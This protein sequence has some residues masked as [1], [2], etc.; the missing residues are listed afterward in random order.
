MAGYWWISCVSATWRNEKGH[1]LHYCTRKDEL[2]SIK[3]FENEDPKKA[4]IIESSYALVAAIRV[5]KEQT[6][7]LKDSKFGG[8]P[9]WPKGKEYPVTSGGKRLGMLAQINCKDVPKELGWPKRGIVQF[10]LNDDEDHD[11]FHPLNKNRSRVIYHEDTKLD[12]IELSVE[13]E[14]IYWGKNYPFNFSQPMK[15]DFML[16]HM[17]PVHP[18]ADVLLNPMLAD[19]LGATDFR[20]DTKNPDLTSSY[21]IYWDLKWHE[22]FPNFPKHYIGGFPAT[23]YI[24]GMRFENYPRYSN[25]LLQISSEGKKDGIGWVDGGQGQFFT[26]SQ[27]LK[28]KDFTDVCFADYF[29]HF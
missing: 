16:G 17:L 9:Y 29:S 10:F 11:S 3:I 7:K 26:S 25:L 28:D 8:V 15:I 2:T 21:W 4:K 20:Y 27:K 19:L 6:P 22:S 23:D 13:Q 1:F 14:P 5:N 24:A 18:S 12:S